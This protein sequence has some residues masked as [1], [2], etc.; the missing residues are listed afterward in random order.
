MK[1]SI[2]TLFPHFFDSPLG[3]SILKRA[4]DQS[5]VTFNIINIRDFAEDKHKV[6]DDRPFG[7]GPGMVLK[8]EPIYKALMSLDALE[9]TGERQGKR[10]QHD[11]KIVVLTSAKGSVFTQETARNFMTKD[12]LIIICGHY[13]GVDERV[14]QHLVDYEMRIGDFVI[15]GGEAA[16]LIMAD[17]VARLVPGV[18]GNEQSN[19]GESHDV[20]GQLGYPQYTRPETFNGWSVPEVLLQGNHALIEK[21]REENRASTI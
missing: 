1:I 16:A 20:P 4:Q 7:G 19:Q 10:K 6:T 11:S 13:E 2:L 14:A 8:V 18:L 12:E 15:T 5:K 21:W 17:A 9:T 3:E